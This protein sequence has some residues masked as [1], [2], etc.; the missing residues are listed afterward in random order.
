MIKYLPRLKG[1]I[2]LKVINE[3]EKNIIYL[4]EGEQLIVKTL[5]KNKVG[6]EIKCKNRSLYVEDI[7]SKDIKNLKI[8]QKELEKLREYNRKNNL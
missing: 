8:E 1:K 5:F 6:I 2:K 7:I 4:D 3:K